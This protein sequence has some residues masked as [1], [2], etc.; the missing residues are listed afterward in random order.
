[1]EL[2]REQPNLTL[3]ELEP[4]ARQIAR[5]S[6]SEALRQQYEEIKSDEEEEEEE[7]EEEEEELL[8]CESCS[9]VVNLMLEPDYGPMLI[10]DC[11][12]CRALCCRACLDTEK[13]GRCDLCVGQECYDEE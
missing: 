10:A 11:D 8:V 6:I 13:I 3:E 1:M 4:I 12:T 7:K 2:K 5:E 9:I